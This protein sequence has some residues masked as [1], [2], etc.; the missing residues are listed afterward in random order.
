MKPNNLCICTQHVFIRIDYQV[1]THYELLFIFSMSLSVNSLFPYTTAIMFTINQHKKFV[2]LDC[3]GGSDDAWALLLLL[4]AEQCGFI[5]LLAVT[6]TGCGNTTCEN[7]ARNMRRILTACSRNDVSTRDY[8]N[9]WEYSRP[10]GP[11]SKYLEP[12]TELL[13]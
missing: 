13:S 11:T 2:I 12:C 4:R 7:A 6:T 10:E 9:N 8:K 5:Q 1:T 3:D